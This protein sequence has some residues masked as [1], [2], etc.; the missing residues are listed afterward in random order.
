M[1]YKYKY[2]INYLILMN[3]H[4]KKKFINRYIHLN[5]INIRNKYSKKEIENYYCKFTYKNN[6][7]KFYIE[8][9]YIQK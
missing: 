1:K 4:I 7:Y 8:C 3:N 5:N 9:I 2:S 6:S